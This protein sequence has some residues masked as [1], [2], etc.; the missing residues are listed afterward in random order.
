MSPESFL[1]MPCGGVNTPLWPHHTS[2]M[3]SCC[4]WG[5][6]A[7]H[8]TGDFHC[9]EG[10]QEV[11]WKPGLS[12]VSLNTQS[13]A[14]PSHCQQAQLGQALRWPIV[15]WGLHIFTSVRV[16]LWPPV[17]VQRGNRQ[18]QRR[19]CNFYHHIGPQFSRRGRQKYLSAVE[20]QHER[21]W[22]GHMMK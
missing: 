21:M 22:R 10:R 17:G 14:R 3:V 15:Q 19:T 8:M 1:S 2:W 6:P 18:D 7:G 20:S 11:E 9:K 16:S 4:S 12:T 13:T 5:R